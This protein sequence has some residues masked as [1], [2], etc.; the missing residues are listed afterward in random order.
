MEKTLLNTKEAAS[1]LDISPKTLIKWRSTGRFH[2]AYRKVGGQVRYHR[3][4]L[5]HFVEST[6]VN[7]IDTDF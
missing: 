1:F 2:L 7:G 3:E 4:D 5:K 6:I